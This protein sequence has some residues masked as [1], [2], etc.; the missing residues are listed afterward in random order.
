VSASQRANVG[1]G[2][3]YISLGFAVAHAGP[4]RN[5]SRPCICWGAFLR[6]LLVPVVSLL[7][8]FQKSDKE[9]RPWWRFD[10]ALVHAFVET[11]VYCGSY[12]IRTASLHEALWR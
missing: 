1:N 11:T 3:A 10:G 7:A 6:S 2:K 5:R 4:K 8:C 12:F 9:K